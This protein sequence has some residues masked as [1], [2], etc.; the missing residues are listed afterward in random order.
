MQTKNVAKVSNM[1]A[2]KISKL[3]RS[4]QFHHIDE[5]TDLRGKNLET[6]SRKLVLNRTVDL[7]QNKSLLSFQK[8]RKAA[9]NKGYMDQIWSGKMNEM[10]KKGF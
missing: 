3:H 4:A 2:G 7:I 10:K 9:K 5:E 6:V 8:Y 1:N